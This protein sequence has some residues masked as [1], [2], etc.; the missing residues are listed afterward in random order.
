M[1]LIDAET[2]FDF[3]IFQEIAMKAAEAWSENRKSEL[4]TIGEDRAVTELAFRDAIVSEKSEKIGKSEK[5]FWVTVNPKNGT[6]LTDIIRATQKMYSKKWI[7]QYA[8]VYENTP[9]GHIHTHGLIKASYE[10]SRA[11]KELGNTVKSFCNIAN[12]HCFKFVVLDAEKATQKMSYI[13]GQKQS[14]KLD[15]VNF[16]IEWRKEEML[17]EVYE[18]EERPILLVPRERETF[19]DNV[20]ETPLPN[21]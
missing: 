14:K 1:D 2:G 9:Q 10:A 13:L 6:K 15:N 8:Y 11:R 20:A 5:Y 4:E 3:E 7:E 18:N 16:T 12:T 19:A 17:K 21:I